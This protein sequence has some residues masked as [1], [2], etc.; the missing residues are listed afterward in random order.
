[1]LACT[2]GF[3]W[4]GADIT[5]GVCSLF[6]YCVLQ[7]LVCKVIS[8]DLWLSFYFDCLCCYIVTWLWVVIVDCF[9]VA[10]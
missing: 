7:G 1:M 2:L 8:C 10:V 9:S 3:E 6:E 4:V 5:G